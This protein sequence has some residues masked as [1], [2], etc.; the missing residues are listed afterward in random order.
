MSRAKT[1]YAGDGMPYGVQLQCPGCGFDHV[2]PVH[3]PQGVTESP[4]AKGLPHWT[5]NGDYERPTVSPSILARGMERVTDEEHAKLMAGEKIEPRPFV[6][7][8][9]VVDGRIQFLSDSTHAL[10]GQTVDLPE[11]DR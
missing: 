1:F 11:I 9:Y 10:S 3:W 6:C 8:S 2:L 7:H 5:F 4:E